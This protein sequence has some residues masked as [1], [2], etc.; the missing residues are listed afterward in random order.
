MRLVLL[1]P[2]GAGKGTQAKMLSSELGLPHVASGDLL[3]QNQEMET[4]L[5]LNSKGFMDRG[6]LVPD[7]LVV[8]M[9]LDR[10]ESQDCAAGYI[11][12]GFPRTVQQADT[13]DIS[14]NKESKLSIE[15]VIYMKVSESHLLRRLGGRIICR[16]CQS[17]YH[18]DNSPPKEEGKCDLCG[19]EL[20]RR[21]D[22]SPEA[23]EERIKVYMG[24]TLPL[25]EYY[26]T[27]SKLAEVNAEG[28]IDSVSVQLKQ[29]IRA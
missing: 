27:Q 6:E 9:V 4:P 28:S 2:P 8:D 12:D 19:K 26:H 22:D 14:L 25:V 20:Y 7:K 16:G 18:V 10:I 24:Q 23:I 1:G 3:R 17:P 15:K 29:V 13:L 11:L 5:G 21:D